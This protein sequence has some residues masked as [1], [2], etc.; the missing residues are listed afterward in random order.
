MATTL[1]QLR[2]GE[3]MRLWKCLWIIHV[4]Q[5]KLLHPQVYVKHQ[6]RTQL[7]VMMKLAAVSE[8]CRLENI[9]VCPPSLP[10]D[11][12]A[13]R[14]QPRPPCDLFCRFDLYDDTAEF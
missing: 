11:M 14:R 10:D 13:V 7:A 5:R 8:A 9:P 12:E 6:L 4:A 1:H 3:E 2:L